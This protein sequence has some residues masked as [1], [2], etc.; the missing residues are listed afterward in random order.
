M[1]G[2]DD[3]VFDKPLDAGQKTRKPGF[4]GWVTE[5]VDAIKCCFRSGGCKK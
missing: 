4:R 3:S 1:T 5:K 2:F